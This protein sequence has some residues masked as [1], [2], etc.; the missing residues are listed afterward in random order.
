MMQEFFILKDSTNPY[1]EMELIDS[2]RYNFNDS[3]INYAL[4][5]SQVTFTMI[6]EETNT[7]KISKAKA[8]IIQVNNNSCE[9]KFILQYKWKPRDVNE[10]GV[11]KGVFEI[12]FNN[13]LYI[14][15]IDL[16]SGNLKV[17]IEEDLVIIIK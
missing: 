7:P 9:E 4:Q 17:P 14:E 16:P 3:V 15:N 6:N 5:D 10:S 13:N 2:G 1:L 12:T 11:F 8:N